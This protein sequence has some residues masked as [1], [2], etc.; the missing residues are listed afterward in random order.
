MNKTILI[1]ITLL[2][3]IYVSAQNSPSGLTP[4]VLADS[5]PLDKLTIGA[6]GGYEFGGIGGNVTYY[7]QRNIGLF[8]GAGWPLTGFGY[9]AGIKLRYAMDDN[10]SVIT[11]FLMFMYGYNTAIRY[12]NDAQYNKLFYNFT[13]GGGVDYRPGKSK[14]GYLTLAVYIPLRDPD[15]KNYI[16]NIDYFYAV[17]NSNKLFP[18]SLSLGYKLIIF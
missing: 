7:P 14:L 2:F 16:N 18:L 5:V 12:P 9:N 1:A 13:F 4:I 10:A 6:G 8:V 15:A 17:G 3:S 11:P